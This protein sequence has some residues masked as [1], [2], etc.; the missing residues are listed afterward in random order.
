M[1]DAPQQPGDIP[2]MSKP[3]GEVKDGGPNDKDARQMAMLAHLSG[4]LASLI[5]GTLAGFAG[6]LIIW[7]IKKDES[8]FVADQAKEALNFQLTLL[9]IY[10][11]CYA[12][13]IV[14]CGFGVPLIGVPFILQIIFAI[15][16]AMKAN[17]GEY[18]RYPFNIRMVT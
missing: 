1:S 18:Y 16:S 11:V 10:L 15:V 4:L 3:V 17:E 7:M 6:P 13:T 14:T 5:T 9:I 12:I 2:E 8:E